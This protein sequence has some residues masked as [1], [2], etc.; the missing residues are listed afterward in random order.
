M[1]G[2]EAIAGARKAGDCVRSPMALG[3]TVQAEVCKTAACVDLACM[4]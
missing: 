1:G 4:Q 2:L 3:C